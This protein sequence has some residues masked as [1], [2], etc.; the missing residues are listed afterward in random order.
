M[1][2]D[3]HQS[4]PMVP[5][6]YHTG[7]NML[8]ERFELT[9]TEFVRPG[10]SK[11]S[12]RGSLTG[13]DG[14]GDTTEP[15]TSKSGRISIDT[16]DWRYNPEFKPPAPGQPQYAWILQIVPDFRD[17]VPAKGTRADTSP[18]TSPTST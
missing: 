14:Q 5:Q 11:F 6:R 4:W 1:P 7:A 15:F 8:P 2:K 17:Q 3:R 12:L 9:F 13:E 18:R 10:K 16:S